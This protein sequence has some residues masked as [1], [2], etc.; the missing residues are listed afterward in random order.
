MESVKKKFASLN[1]TS[2]TFDEVLILASIIEKESGH[3]DELALIS[4][5]FHNRLAVKMR[6]QSDPT[7]IYAITDG[8]GKM[9]RN[10][11]RKD[12][13]FKSPHNTYRNAGLPPTPICCPGE[14]AILAAMN[15]ATSNYYYFVAIPD[16][17][18]H[19]FTEGYK[20]HLKTINILRHKTN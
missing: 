15:P 9:E 1:K 8:Y 14:N 6:L 11:T 16:Q 2:L 12:L 5:V 4:S 3:K 13:W 20:E 17:S 18:G 7:V 10:L 19:I